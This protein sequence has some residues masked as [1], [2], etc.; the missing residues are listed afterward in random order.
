M[1]RT[2][3]TLTVLMLVTMVVG[4]SRAQ[5]QGRANAEWLFWSR[6]NDANQTLI[7]PSALSADDASFNYSSG[8][9]FSAGYGIGDYDIEAV[10]S[11]IPNWQADDS[12]VLG[13][14]LLLNDDPMAFLG[15]TNT[16][17]IRN[18]LIDAALADTANVFS[19]DPGATGQFNY[20]SSLRDFQ[21]NI[22]TN[23]TMRPYWASLGWRHV[24]LDENSS[25]LVTGDFQ[26]TDAM[27]GTM[28]GGPLG[29]TALTDIGYTLVQGDG[30]FAGYD[31]A[32]MMPTITTIGALFQGVTKN[33][34]D[35]GQVVLGGRFQPRDLVSLEVFLTAGLYQNRAEGTLVET[36]FA[37]AN[38]DDILQRRFSNARKVASFVGGL[39][40][41]LVIPVTD[42]IFLRAGYEGM[43][44]TNVAL[45]PE[46]AQGLG[47]TLLGEQYYR[48]KTGGIL[49]AHGGN[50][51]LGITW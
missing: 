43:V 22:G 48:V 5:A 28:P 50:L 37:V 34:L 35:G 2:K 26:S 39:G 1:T 4:S 17:G 16:L 36:L 46:Q 33:D 12:T 42:Y 10:F 41:R 40:F 3:I 27:A 23:R 32:A 7:G 47:T 29:G 14:P 18:G 19:L 21:L 11:Q 15:A 25:L 8:F 20:E 6:N 49:V 38:D 31:P 51:G 30:S 9:R 44:V 45:A 24:E 13:S